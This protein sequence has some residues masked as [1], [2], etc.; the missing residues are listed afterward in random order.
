M[1]IETHLKVHK[2]DYLYRFHRPPIDYVV[3][4]LCEK[5]LPAQRL[6]FYQLSIGRIHLH[7]W[8]DFKKEW[9]KCV[10]KGVNEIFWRNITLT[11]TDG[12]AVVLRFFKTDSLYA[13]I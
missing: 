10:V 4:V 11:P 9:K 1:K 6:R 8:E 12:Y 13:N 3:Y 5:L 2:H 7:W